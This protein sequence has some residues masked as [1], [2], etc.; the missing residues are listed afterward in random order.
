MITRKQI[1]AA[2]KMLDIDNKFMSI[3]IQVDDITYTFSKLHIENMAAREEMKMA[4]EK[5]ELEAKKAAEEKAKKEAER[6]AA[7]TVPMSK[8]VSRTAGDILKDK[9]AK[10]GI[11]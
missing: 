11:E 7:K 5:A 1:F 4:R 6:K 10:K 9:E 3:S 8:K 2:K